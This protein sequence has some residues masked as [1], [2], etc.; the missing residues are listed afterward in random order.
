MVQWQGDL[1]DSLPFN[2]IISLEGGSDTVHSQVVRATLA[3]FLG[4]WVS[5]GQCYVMTHSG[6]ATTSQNLWKSPIK[7]FKNV[8]WDLKKGTSEGELYEREGI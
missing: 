5:A 2:H 6:T 7:G 4:K 1:L 3:L 8:T